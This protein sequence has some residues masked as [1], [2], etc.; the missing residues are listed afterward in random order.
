MVLLGIF[1]GLKRYTGLTQIRNYQVVHKRDK[2]N[3]ILTR[4]GSSQCEE[5]KICF[6][7]L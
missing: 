4:T 6:G 5:E 3:F 1:L 2:I 7:R